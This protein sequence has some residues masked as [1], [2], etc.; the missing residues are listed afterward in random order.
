MIAVRLTGD[1]IIARVG[2]R[3]TLLL[4]A[5][6]G[7]AGFAMIATAPALT[8]LMLGVVLS[9]MGLAVMA[10]VAFSAAGRSKAPGRAIARVA[11][12]GYAGLLSGPVFMGYVGELFSLSVAF[13]MLSALLL[14]AALL[15]TS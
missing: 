4:S 3:S 7:A 1:A 15:K 12:G 5:L 13:A 11:S 2:H 10:P 6:F 14:T 9:G 8:Y